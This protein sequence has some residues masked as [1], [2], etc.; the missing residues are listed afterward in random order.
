M[1]ERDEEVRGQVLKTY[2]RLARQQR[3]CVEKQ[4]DWRADRMAG[5]VG[6]AVLLWNSMA[7]LTSRLTG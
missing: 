7:G 4:A 6:R 3:V 1:R 2:S 5:V